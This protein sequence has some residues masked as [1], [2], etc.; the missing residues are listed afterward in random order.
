MARGRHRARR[1]VSRW[2]L[3]SGLTLLLWLADND[4]L[5]ATGLLGF[6]GL[7]VALSVLWP[8]ALILALQAPGALVPNRARIWW[9]GGDPGRPHVPDWLRRAVYAADGRRCCLPWCETRAGSLELDHLRP[10]SL[11]GRTSFW[12]MMTLCK[13]HNLVKSNYWSE[14]GFSVYRP[15]RGYSNR[16]EAARILAF[17]RRHRWSPLRLIRAAMAL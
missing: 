16:H 11:G 2:G 5:G 3:P 9:R 14:D 17:E 6:L 12:N 1:Q 8:V 15:W 10:W 4:P 7:G 13:A